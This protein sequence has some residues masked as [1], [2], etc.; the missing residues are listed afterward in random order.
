MSE[1]QTVSDKSS[2]KIEYLMH[3]YE[4]YI[5]N[6]NNM[7]NFYLVAASLWGGLYMQIITSDNDINKYIKLII[8]STGALISIIFV[9]IHYSSR[10]EVDRIEKSLR[11]AESALFGD[12]KAFLTQ[13]KKPFF[14]SLKY[15]IPAVY[16]IFFV[17]FT[18]L[19]WFTDARNEK[20][21]PPCIDYR[22]DFGP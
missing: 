17:S 8:P 4:I 22:Y 1:Y 16:G 14:L 2:Q 20:I 11:I 19:W 9:C 5:T 18:L 10:I 15:L 13:G 3:N 6:I 21:E 7:F 12:D